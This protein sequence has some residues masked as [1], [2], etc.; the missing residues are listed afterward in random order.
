MLSWPLA[1]TL[2]VAL[3]L[4]AIAGMADG[5]ALTATFATRQTAHAAQL[6]G[7]IFVTAASLKVGSFAI[8]AA[9]AGPVV[10]ALGA[11]GRDRRRGLPRDAGR[12]IGLPLSRAPTPKR[13]ARAHREALARQALRR[14]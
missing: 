11:A 8:G 2:P 4:V 3:A 7:Q 5:P 13:L 10:L 14:T 9:L 12:G 6:H 1:T